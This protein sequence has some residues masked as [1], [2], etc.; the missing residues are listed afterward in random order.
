MLDRS[1]YFF[2]SNYNGLKI[3]K[4]IIVVIEGVKKNRLYLLESSSVH[5]LYVLYIKTDIDRA[6]L[7]YLKLGT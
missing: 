2:K 6:K 5:M 7:W 3:M 4:N 1:G